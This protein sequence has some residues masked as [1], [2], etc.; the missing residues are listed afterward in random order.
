MGGGGIV[1]LESRLNMTAV[2]RG[3]RWEGF[4]HARSGRGGGGRGGTEA[5]KNQQDW[6]TKR[7]QTYSSTHYEGL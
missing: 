2:G 6:R 4:L 3:G 7:G 1:L 5:A